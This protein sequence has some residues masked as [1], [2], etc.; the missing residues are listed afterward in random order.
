M[1]QSDSKFY[2]KSNYEKSKPYYEN[3]GSKYFTAM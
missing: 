2:K 1:K 3:Y